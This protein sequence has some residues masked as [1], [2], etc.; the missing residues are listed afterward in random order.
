VVVFNRDHLSLDNISDSEEA[1][2]CRCS[3]AE[4]DREREA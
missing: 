4:Q 3:Q 2:Q 1:E